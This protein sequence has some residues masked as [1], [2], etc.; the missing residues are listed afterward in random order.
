MANEMDEKLA[1]LKRLAEEQLG[2]GAGWIL[3]NPSLVLELLKHGR[4]R[5]SVVAPGLAG[6]LPEK[7]Q[8]EACATEDAE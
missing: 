7:T 5:R 1:R 8:A 4:E 2:H 3:I 6:G